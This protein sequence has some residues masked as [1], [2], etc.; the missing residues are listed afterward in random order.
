MQTPAQHA[1]RSP[2]GSPHQR[3]GASVGFLRN[4]SACHRALPQVSEPKQ[5]RQHAFQ[6]AV[7]VDLVTA[8]VLELVGI[9]QFAKS[10]LAQQGTPTDLLFALLEPG[11]HFIFKETA[12]PR[13]VWGSG[14]FVLFEFIRFE[15]EG[16]L[17]PPLCKR[18]AAARRASSSRP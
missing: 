7:Q 16:I 17:P 1:M 12:Q 9:E 10:L 6:L 2:A 13:D 18:L 3:A 5:H 11:E 14:F 15:F 4:G 8:E